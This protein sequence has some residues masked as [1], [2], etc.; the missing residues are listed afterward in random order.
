MARATTALTLR[1]ILLFVLGLPYIM[2]VAMVYRPKVVTAD[3]PQKQLGFKYQPVR[4][5]ATDGVTIDGWWI[6]AISIGS[7]GETPA[8]TPGERT[9]ILCHGL[10]ANKANQLM[11]ARELIPHGYNVLAFD[12]PRTGAAA[13]RSA[14]SATWS[15]GMCSAPCGGS[16][17]A[18]RSNRNS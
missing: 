7:P 16:G 1:V 6:P 11:L 13:A 18:T 4:F 14:A 12:F 5:A 17:P 15:G 2:A 9:V 3:T 8:F 10:G